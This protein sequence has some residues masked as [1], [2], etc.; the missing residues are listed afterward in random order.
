MGAGFAIGKAHVD[1]WH[2]G[3]GSNNIRNI[4]F[5]PHQTNPLILLTLLYISVHSLNLI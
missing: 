3:I 5:P 2:R 4:T 1:F